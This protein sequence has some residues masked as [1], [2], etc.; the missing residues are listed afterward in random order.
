MNDILTLLRPRIWSVKN[1][2]LSK[3]GLFKFFLLGTIGALFWSGLFV[4]SMRVLKYFQSIEEIGNIIS[5]KLLSMILITSFALLI[6]SSILTSLSKLYLSRDLNLV[7]SMPVSGYKIFIARWIDS[8][9]ESSWMV[10]VYILPVLIAYGITYKGGLFFYFSIFTSLVSLSVIASAISSVLIMLTVLLVPANR[11]KT[12]FIFLGTLLFMFLYIAIR[13]LRPE[14]LVDPDVFITALVYIRNIQTPE[15]P[16]LAST[17]AYDAIKAAISGD[18]REGFFHI[19][20]SWSCAVSLFYLITIVAESI[21]FKGYSKTQT[22]QIRIFKS[23]KA[24]Y[25]FLNFLPNHIRAFA[26][27]E[28][29]TF[30]RDQSQW[31]QLFL[32][33]GLVVI[34]V[35]NFKVLPVEK[36]QMPTIYLQNLLAFLNMG[37]ALFVLT[38][39]TA[40][41][42]Y[43]AV[44]MEKDAFW[45]VK[46][47]PVPLKIFL[48]TKFFIYYLPLLILTEILI[49]AT[50]IFLNVTPFMMILSTVTVF[51]LVPGIVSMGIGFGAAYPDFK[52]ENPVQTVTGYGG[53]L[54]MMICAAYIA[55]VIILEAGPV[56]HLFMSDIK[57]RAF[58]FRGWIWV[59][60]S[61]SLSFLISIIG[62]ILPMK[63]GEAKLTKRFR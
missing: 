46:T 31:S 42:A 9:T 12:I 37:L 47:A 21:Y 3:G 49:V 30:F 32:I 20:L 5:Y 27:K 23:D 13:L 28:I 43:P 33:A 57:G 39:V 29:K 56:Y 26:V 55:G 14:L 52:A 10:I 18:M 7:H 6:F 4:V 36:T 34:Y 48:W 2:G 58:S 59:I 62:I 16:Y 25:F 38:A 53:I 45:I 61:F 35:Y 22:A 44:S 50:N 19:L 60:S 63:F 41:F 24:G 17:W 8:T 51:F 15:S 54:F 40:R 1:R 11:M